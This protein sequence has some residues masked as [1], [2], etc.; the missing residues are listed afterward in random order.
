MRSDRSRQSIVRAMLLIAVLVTAF[1]ACVIINAVAMSVRAEDT[2]TLPT[3]E[4]T[5]FTYDEPIYSYTASSLAAIRQAMDVVVHYPDGSS[6]E[7]GFND[8]SIEGN[9][10]PPTSGTT[11]KFQK[12][13]NV[14]Y[15][16]E[17]GGETY[18]ITAPWTFTVQAA[19]PARLRVTVL[20]NRVEAFSQYDPND[21]LVQV[22]YTDDDRACLLYT[23]DAADEL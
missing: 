6:Q 23:S 5:G 17:T 7:L 13:L 14:V 9:F 20:T 4:I 2:V 16:Y 10:T 15:T 11:G 18:R 3:I 21:F 19:T 1:S 12:T 8:F 22:E